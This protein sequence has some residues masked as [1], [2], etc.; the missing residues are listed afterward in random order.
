MNSQKK[1]LI[2][3]TSVDKF[4][5]GK[6]TGWY[7]SEAVHPYNEFVK[8]GFAVDF[9]SISGGATVDPGSL[10]GDE[11]CQKFCADDELRAKTVN[12]PALATVD[13]SAYDALFFAAGF[14]VMWDF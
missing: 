1:V 8:A 14:G 2:V 13:S 4:P 6:P 11:E 7:I 9:A 5:S 3:L 12:A 10:P